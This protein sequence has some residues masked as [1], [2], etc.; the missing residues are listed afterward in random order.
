[1]AASCN[2]DNGDCTD[3]FSKAGPNALSTCNRDKCG[4]SDQDI[5]PPGCYSP[6]FSAS[7]DFSQ[8]LCKQ[9]KVLLKSCPFFDAII[10]SSYLNERDLVFPDPSSLFGSIRNE[11]WK[12]GYEGYARCTKPCQPPVGQN[13]S[14]HYGIGPTGGALLTGCGPLGC[15]PSQSPWVWAGPTDKLKRVYPARSLELWLQLVEIPAVGAFKVAISSETF[16][17]GSVQGKQGTALVALAFKNSSYVCPNCVLISGVWIHVFVQITETVIFFRTETFSDGNISEYR[18]NGSSVRN[19]NFSFPLVQDYGIG[20]GRKIPD[21]L[22]LT[23]RHQVDTFSYFRGAVSGLRLWGYA[24]SVSNRTFRE[25]CPQLV[26]LLRTDDLLACF[27]FNSSL[28]DHLGFSNLSPRSGDKFLPWCTAIDDAGRS[29]IYAA[30][31]PERQVDKG[32]NWGFC[33]PGLPLPSTGFSY[34]PAHMLALAQSSF[35][36]LAALYPG[37]GRVP[38]LFIGNYAAGKGGA[39]YRDSCDTGSFRRSSCFIDGG[40]SQTGSDPAQQIVFNSNIAGIAGG[41]VYVECTTFGPACT[42]LLNNTVHLPFSRGEE[43]KVYFESNQAGGWGNDLATAPA[44]IDFVR[45]NEQSTVSDSVGPGKSRQLSSTPSDSDNADFSLLD[46]KS[47]Q[48]IPGLESM[49]FTVVLF[50]NRSMIVRDSENVIRVRVCASVADGGCT[51]DATSLIPVPFFPFDPDSGL[52]RV[53]GDHPIVCAIG[54][55]AVDVHFSVAGAVIPP[56][57]AKVKCLLCPEGSSHLED[58]VRGIWKCVFCLASQYIIDSNNPAH[59]CQNCPTGGTCNG[60]VLVGLVDGEIW[61]TDLSKGQYLLTSCPPGFY[62]S[63]TDSTGVFSHDLQECKLCPASFYCLGGVTPRSACPS[64]SFAPAGT[65]A[66]RFCATATFVDV[67]VRMPVP[68]VSFDKDKQRQFRS[69]MADASGV[70]PDRVSILRIAAVSRR[71]GNSSVVSGSA[72]LIDSNIAAQTA[73]A[74][75]LITDNLDQAVLN[76]YL[77][78]QGLPAVTLLSVTIQKNVLVQPVPVGLIVGVTVAGAV[79]LIGVGVFLVN[80][81]MR[82]TSSPEEIRLK[83][84]VLGLRKKLGI[85][86]EDGFILSSESVPWFWRGRE[87]VHLQRSHVEAGARM[88]LYQPFDTN[89]FDAFCLCLEGEKRTVHKKSTCSSMFSGCTMKTSSD[90]KNDDKSSDKGNSILPEEPYQLLCNV[91]LHVATELLRPD[92]CSTKHSDA[93]ASADL[94]RKPSILKSTLAP[95]MSLRS[96]EP[97]WIGEGESLLPVERRSRYF[98]SNVRKLRIWQDDDHMLFRRLQV[99]IPVNSPLDEGVLFSC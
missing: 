59:R 96:G 38:L 14:V 18:L 28:S 74:A 63:N 42:Q 32:E 13:T 50:D 29:I 23:Q 90:K 3:Q 94:E 71:D 64:Q 47:P 69:A 92:V 87:V 11:L 73:A 56:L 60:S 83:M 6:C 76:Q 21:A 72:V 10:Y 97:I 70:S 1:M 45:S 88:C 25:S 52:C 93:Q 79:V 75:E 77:L 37:C 51:D 80:Q 99:F 20:I 17:L 16:A 82:D 66:S 84:A 67:S 95:A 35:K 36:E 19:S 39:V 30:T 5:Y 9:E 91:V 24:S 22:Y 40:A 4:L 31:A 27:D 43:Y 65:N 7:C 86:R 54:R 8:F 33:S 81:L 61:M 89:Q 85:L 68:P 78:R 55:S 53:A 58:S 49:N 41:A 15:T 98:M 12:G 57:V 2:F 44:K 26:A 48:Y 34:D 46:S 62:L